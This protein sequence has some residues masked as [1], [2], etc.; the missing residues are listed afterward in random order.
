M[1]VRSAE[2]LGMIL[3]RRIAVGL[4]AIYLL[5]AVGAWAGQRFLVYAPDAEHVDP[6]SIGLASVEERR[7]ATPDG[8][9]VLA[10]YARA[11]PGR[12]TL[13][14]FH[15]NGGNLALRADRIRRFMGQGLGVYMM[16][17]RGYSGSSG[18]PSEKANVADARLAYADLR[19]LG[20]EPKDIVIYGES[21]GTG[22]AVQV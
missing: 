16:S 8:V 2:G 15:G 11:K 9:T 4:A 19:Q 20:L 10:W 1:V 12:P 7:L 17:Y 22:V 5:I 18:V 6:R 13:L 21:L 3:L 14:Y